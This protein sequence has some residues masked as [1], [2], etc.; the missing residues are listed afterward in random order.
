MTPWNQVTIIGVGL[1]G[2]SLGLALKK[3]SLARRVVGVGHRQASLDAAKACGA[4]DETSLDPAAGVR[5]SDLVV[6]GNSGNSS[7]SRRRPWR[8]AYW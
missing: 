3:A 1:I 7:C 2:G 5:G 6:S 4:A 8:P